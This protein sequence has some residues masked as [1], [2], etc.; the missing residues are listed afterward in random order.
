[1]LWWGQPS[2][3]N[4]WALVH[5]SPGSLSATLHSWPLAFCGILHLFWLLVGKKHVFKTSEAAAEAN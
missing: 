1:M 3:A 4:R 2:A 5:C